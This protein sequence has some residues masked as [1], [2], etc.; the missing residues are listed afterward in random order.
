M[1][2]L[3]DLPD[4]LY[5]KGA[6]IA[7]ARGATIQQLIVDAVAREVRGGAENPGEREI[8][9]PLIRSKSPGSLDLS[10]FDFDDL[11]A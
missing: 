3:V 7:A 9:L 10:Q 5:R 8:E 4:S 2:T 6:E 1:Q 11:L